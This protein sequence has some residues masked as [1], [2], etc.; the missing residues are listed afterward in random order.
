MRTL[1]LLLGMGVGGVFLLLAVWKV[2][3]CF[4]LFM[5]GIHDDEGFD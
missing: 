2:W 1:I 3:E 4:E 5:E